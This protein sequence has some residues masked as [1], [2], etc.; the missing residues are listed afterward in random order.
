MQWSQIVPFL[1]NITKHPN[2][3]I[4]VCI[5]C[6]ILIIGMTFIKLF[7]YN[8]LEKFLFHLYPI[9]PKN[10]REKNSRTHLTTIV[11]D[12]SATDKNSHYTYYKSHYLEYIDS[13]PQQMKV[14]H[15]VYTSKNVDDILAERTS[16]D[17]EEVFNEKEKIDGGKRFIAKCKTPVEKGNLLTSSFSC[18]LQRQSIDL[19]ED[20]WHETTNRPT[21]EMHLYFIFPG[22]DTSHLDLSTYTYDSTL[23]K[24]IKKRINSQR[25]LFKFI[26]SN[27]NKC[28][29]WKIEWP[30]K[31]LAYRIEWS[32]KKD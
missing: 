1:V 19:D 25:N 26:D 8:P 20:Y 31:D 24:H 7:Q 17:F 4:T 32:K 27:L 10:W 12:M 13:E 3:F 18:K 5:I 21:K 14:S 6:I 16:F 28:L 29:L 15:C 11:V 9:K 30:K 22:S 23:G 2:L